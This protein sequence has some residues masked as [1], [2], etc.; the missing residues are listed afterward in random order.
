M[1]AWL[2]QSGADIYTRDFFERPFSETELRE[3][4]SGLTVES[5]FS[6]SSPYF[7]K[8]GVDRIHLTDNE[9]ISMMLGEPRL[10]RRPLIFV[11]NEIMEPV[12]GADRIIERL[13]GRI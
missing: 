5:V 7:R 1:R 4:L 3:V 13:K 8:I 11:D 12:S 9:L 6:W 2:S 10:I